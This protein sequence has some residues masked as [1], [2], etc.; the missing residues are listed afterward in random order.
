[1]AERGQVPGP[2][3]APT[4]PPQQFSMGMDSFFGASP[5]GG[6]PGPFMNRPGQ[7][8]K[9]LSFALKTLWGAG[10]RIKFE[11]ALIE[12]VEVH[13]RFERDGSKWG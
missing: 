1:M 4:M 5:Q 12:I 9:S 10:A 3:W 11:Y 7:V 8:R 2:G 6:F 13:C